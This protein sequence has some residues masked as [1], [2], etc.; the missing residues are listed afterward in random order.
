MQLTLVLTQDCNLRCDYC[1]AGEK[2][3]TIMS[4][5]TAY[6]AID[7]CFENCLESSMGLS[8]FGGEPL[9][10]WELLQKS[11]QYFHEHL[12]KSV[13]KVG[14]SVTT[15]GTLLDREKIAWLKEHHF[16][17]GLSLD[18]MAETHNILRKLQTGGDSF[19]RCSKS[20]DD[21]IEMKPN[22]SVII[23]VDPRNVTGIYKG[24]V[25]LYERGVEHITLNMNYYIEWSKRDLR[26][27]KK[28]YKKLKP[29]F[30]KCA[31]GDRPLHISSISNKIVT[32]V[33]ESCRKDSCQFGKRSMVV[34]PSGNIYPC[35]RVVGSD[36]DEHIQMGSIHTGF[37]ALNVERVLAESGNSNE[38]CKECIYRSRCVNWCGCV[39]YLTTGHIGKTSGVVCFHEQ[40]TIDIADEIVAA[41]KGITFA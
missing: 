26:N 5:E 1:Y 10:E 40:V 6:K 24:V 27:L 32:T 33:E 23:V 14:H 28:M 30:I 41:A 12:P 22:G 37:K 3:P 9:L 38:E 11:V 18:G 21:F 34:A 17:L 2:A 8:F 29:F 36:D 39:N 31:K 7:F 19:A 20:L 16:R 13:T 4:E 35:D 15:N 25:G